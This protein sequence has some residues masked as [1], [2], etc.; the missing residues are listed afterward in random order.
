VLAILLGLG[1]SLSWG[2]A[3]F[4]GGLASRRSRVLTVVLLSQAAGL[5]LMLSVAAIRGTGPP[6]ARDMALGAAAG[7]AGVIG[8]AAFYRGL[9]VGAMSLVAPIAA[10][11]V[12]VPVVAG[13]AGGDRPSAIAGAGA[14]LAVG[15]AILA[16]RAPGPATR[17][18]LGLAVVAAIGFGTFFVLLA[19]AADQDAVWAVCAA[20]F[21]SVPLVAAV[22]L[23]LRERIAVRRGDLRL[24]LGAGILDAAANL[25]FAVASQEGLL[26][27]V[28]VLGSLYP[29]VTVVLARSFLGERL[30]VGQTTGVG[31]ALAGVGL[32]A[33]GA[34]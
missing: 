20:R 30:G 15:G 22:A 23:A 6:P 8:L 18:G 4:W 11:G 9:S 32:I 14:V 21:A 24:V 2:I 31:A 13:I 19:P 12:V 33:A 27:L 1:S 10:L 17:R 5:A 25:A 34:G 28:A 26:S 29:V 3:D 16:S 7:A